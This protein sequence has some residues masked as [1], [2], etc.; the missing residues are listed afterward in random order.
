VI[1][2][3]MEKD[4]VLFV[5]LRGGQDYRDVSYPGRSILAL[6]NEGAG[7][8]GWVLKSGN[9]VGIPIAEGVDSLNVVVAAGII[10]SRMIE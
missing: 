4:Y 10:A 2:D 9:P 8:S 3:L 7:L 5:A 1:N 6:G